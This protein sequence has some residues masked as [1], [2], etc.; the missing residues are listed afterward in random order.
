[1]LASCEPDS[2][3][4]DVEKAVEEL[5]QDPDAMDC[6]FASVDPTVLEKAVEEVAQDPVAIDCLFKSSKRIG[7]IRRPRGRSTTRVRCATTR[8]FALARAL[9]R[10]NARGRQNAGASART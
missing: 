5:A 2:A 9:G 3:F 4:A 6:L 7:I 1:M 10:Q 8:P